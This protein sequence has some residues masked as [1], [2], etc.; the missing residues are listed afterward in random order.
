MPIRIVEMLKNGGNANGNVSHICRETNNIVT[1]GPES[2][3]LVKYFVCKKF[4][5]ML[6]WRT[7]QD[8][9]EKGI[10]LQCLFP[11]TKRI[12]TK[13]KNGLWTSDLWYLDFVRIASDVF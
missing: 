9:L 8:T 10:C 6:S 12:E 1:N 4:V 11:G 2:S 5:E 7:I 3:K 13:R